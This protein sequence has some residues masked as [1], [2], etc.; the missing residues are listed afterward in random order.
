MTKKLVWGLCGAIGAIAFTG[1]HPA[2][3]ATRM[4]P[5]GMVRIPSA[6]LQL[7]SSIDDLVFAVEECERSRTRETDPR[8]C[9]PDEFSDELSSGPRTKVAA[10]YLDRQEV[11][12]HAYQRCVQAARCR[13][14]PVEQMT[15]SISADELPVVFVSAVDAANYCHFV[16]ARLP[17][18]AEF[19]SAARGENRRTFPW[20]ANFHTLRAN[21]GAVGATS[22]AEE[23]GYELLAPVNSFWS[24][25]TPQ[26][27]FNLAGNASEWTDSPFLPHGSNENE[28]THLRVVKGGSFAE[29][30]QTL[31]GSARRGLSSRSREPSVG[32]RC[33]RSLSRRPSP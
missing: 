5:W 15:K 3:E 30:R 1:A 2:A 7:G 18:E 29:P 4:A 31:R 32:F 11:S 6:T 16:D 17:T 8:K 28:G 10:F 27:V 24:G 20:G 13:P 19:E 12:T 33:A 25:K 26:G 22:T 23:D 14:L 9:S 21:S